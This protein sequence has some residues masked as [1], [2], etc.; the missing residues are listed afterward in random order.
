MDYED[1]LELIKTRRSI[2]SFTDRPVPD[3]L[4]E[5]V[6]EAGRWA[7]SG[8]NSQPWEFIVIR[9]QG[10]KDQMADWAGEV[11]TLTH[12]AELRR[13]E[14]LRWP[15]AARPPVSGPFFKTS[16]VLILVIG[17]PRVSK[18]F[19]L[20]V[21]TE[22]QEANFIS[23]LAGAF[24]GM[25][26]AAATLGLGCHWTSTVSSAYPSV[27]I[28]D[29]LGIPEGYRIYDMMGLGYPAVEP[30]PRLVRE[31]E[32]MT[33]YERFDPAKYRTDEQ[34]REWLISLRK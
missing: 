12:K 28:K 2:R 18:S 27:M 21:Y 19:P 6:V 8:A 26:L 33:H 34:I 29:L 22:R 14:D 7:P 5:K 13:P 1:L 9:D 23:A 32:A 24:L 31:R 25:T 16:P 11:Q 30:R 4:V 15:S 10:T 3:E 17:D 20:L